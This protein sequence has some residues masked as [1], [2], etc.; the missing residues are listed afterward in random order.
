M[1]RQLIALAIFAALLTGCINR[2]PP[3]P[4]ETV[5]YTPIAAVLKWANPKDALFDANPKEVVRL[6]WVVWEHDR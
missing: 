4:L 1:K 3:N 2:T 6:Y 5:V